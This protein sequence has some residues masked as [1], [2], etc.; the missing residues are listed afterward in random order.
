MNS[1]TSILAQAHTLSQQQE[2]DM[3]LTQ[4]LEGPFGVRRSEGRLWV[5]T[6]RAESRAG[7]C[8]LCSLIDAHA[9]VL[10][11]LKQPHTEPCLGPGV[12]L[13]IRFP[14]LPALPGFGGFR[15]SMAFKCSRSESE[16]TR[17]EKIPPCYYSVLTKTGPLSG[18]LMTL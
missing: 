4:G 14:R 10:I 7:G 16:C 17:P 8:Q 2:C 6:G 12:G 15:D 9:T 18:L 11:K 3:E 13:L 1:P 5:A